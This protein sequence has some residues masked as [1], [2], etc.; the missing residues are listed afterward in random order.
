[1]HNSVV[2][3]AGLAV[4]AAVVLSGCATMTADQCVAADWQAIG[5]QDA[6]EGRAAGHLEHHV[7]AC[8]G[9]G[10]TADAAAYASGHTQGAR[11]FCT[12]AN[13]FRLGR[14]GGTNNNICPDDL[15]NDF[16]VTYE[17]GRGLYT[18]RQAASRAQSDLDSLERR[19]QTLDQQISRDEAAITTLNL[20]PANRSQLQARINANREEHRR[21]SKQRKRAREQVNRTN[22]D[23]DNY[24]DKV[25]DA[26]LQGS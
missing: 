21:L 22:R 16:I 17:A 7:A 20:G 6:M 18:R 25:E 24:R 14:S 12:P 10:V 9:H 5:H 2:P 3:A 23:Y 19:M 13:G 4:L 8:T 15:A 26:L 1:M 11:A